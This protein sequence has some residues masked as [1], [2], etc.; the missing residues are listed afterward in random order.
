MC[1]NGALDKVYLKEKTKIRAGSVH[2]AV[3]RI[4]QLDSLLFVITWRSHSEPR[5]EKRN[6]RI[7][8]CKLAKMS[9]DDAMNLVMMIKLE[10]QQPHIASHVSCRCWSSGVRAPPAQRFEDEDKSGRSSSCAQ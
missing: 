6:L 9:S 5:V 1:E 2:S 4:S 8:F 10:P 7:G 3:G